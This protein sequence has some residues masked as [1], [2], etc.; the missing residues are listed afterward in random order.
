MCVCVC[1]AYRRPLAGVTSLS[2]GEVPFSPG[3]ARWYAQYKSKIECS[4]EESRTRSSSRPFTNPN[5]TLEAFLDLKNSPD[6]TSS[7]DASL[8]S[9]SSLLDNVSCVCVCVHVWMLSEPF[10]GPYFCYL[11]SLE[12]CM[13]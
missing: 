11:S 13:Y 10:E 6:P 8:L 2:E 7:E 1:V 4:S 9:G 5:S 12:T 3:D